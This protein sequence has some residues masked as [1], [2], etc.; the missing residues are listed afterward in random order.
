MLIKEQSKGKYRTYNFALGAYGPHQM[1]HMLQTGFL[2]TVNMKKKPVSA[3]YLAIT[4][5]IARSAC[6]YNYFIWD[7]NGPRYECQEEELT[8]TPGFFSEPLTNPHVR[9]GTAKNILDEMEKEYSELGIFHFLIVFFTAYRD[10]GM[11]FI[12]LRY[13][14]GP[15]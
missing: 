11:A 4:D 12:L 14:K 10:L 3:I 5:H 15:V 1:L 6:K 13:R 8:A 7:I 9:F 2:D